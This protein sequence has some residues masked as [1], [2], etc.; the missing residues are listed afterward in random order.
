V[1]VYG[2]D[3]KN[4]IRA[5]LHALFKVAKDVLLDNGEQYRHVLLTK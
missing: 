5:E 2:S 1:P 3:H 4:K